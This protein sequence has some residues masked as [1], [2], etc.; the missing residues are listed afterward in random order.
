MRQLNFANWSARKLE[1]AR[2]EK[3]KKEQEEQD[4]KKS[5]NKMHDMWMSKDR[6]MPFEAWKKRKEIER[7]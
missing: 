4:K 3:R 5:L 7:K 1:E 2:K 6:V